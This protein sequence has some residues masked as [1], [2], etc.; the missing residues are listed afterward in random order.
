MTTHR[1]TL[2][3][4][5]IILTV[6]ITIYIK[7]MYMLIMTVDVLSIKLKKIHFMLKALYL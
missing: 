2:M 4:K 6:E 7:G 3:Y 1:K 5:K